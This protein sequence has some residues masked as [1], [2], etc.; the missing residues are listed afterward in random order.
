MKKCYT[1]QQLKDESDFNRN[2]S[3]KDGLGSICKECNRRKARQ[4]Y[5]KNREKHIRVCVAKRK[6]ASVESGRKVVE[7]K[8]Q[9]GCE[10]GCG[11][12][13]P[14]CLDFHHLKDKEGLISRMVNQGCCWKTIQKEIGKCK[15]VCSNCHR[16]IH[17][18][19]LQL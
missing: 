19:K 14:C 11:E 16:K 15:V 3:K 5:E 12:T 18:G 1:C 4:Y 6:K 2:K 17:A 10:M 7:F 8:L 13:D 9:R